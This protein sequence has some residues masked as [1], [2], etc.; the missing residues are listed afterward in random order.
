MP[1]GN[2]IRSNWIRGI[3]GTSASRRQA[4]SEK[5]SR[6]IGGSATNDSGFG[7]AHGL[8]WRFLER[9]ER[10]LITGGSA[11]LGNRGCTGC[12]QVAVESRGG[13][14]V[15]NK[16]LDRWVARGCM[17]R[18]RFTPR[19]SL[20]RKPACDNCKGDA[21]DTG[22]DVAVAAGAGRPAD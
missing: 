18:K 5:L 20:R 7:L 15:Q 1:P 13:V 11:P 19:I 22:R 12:P 3:G 14:D 2:F 4:W 8:G 17:D 10:R 21:Q 16:L 9:T 6:R